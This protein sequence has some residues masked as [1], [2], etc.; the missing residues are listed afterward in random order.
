MVVKKWKAMFGGILF[1]IIF[2]P[3]SPLQKSLPKTNKE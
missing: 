2:D 1:F 3:F